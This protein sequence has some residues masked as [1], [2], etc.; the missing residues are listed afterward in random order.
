MSAENKLIDQQM[1]ADQQRIFHRTRGNFKG[2]KQKGTN[3]QGQ[4]QGKEQ[5]LTIFSIP[6][7]LAFVGL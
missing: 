2:L 4:D 6:G 5:S 7:F 3:N 1:I